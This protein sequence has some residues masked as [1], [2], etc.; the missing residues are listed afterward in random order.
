MKTA[1]CLAVLMTVSAPAFPQGAAP[2]PAPA[3][4]TPSVQE[5]VYEGEL[6]T[7]IATG[8]ESTGWRLRRRTPEGRREYIEVLLTADV[9]QG[10]RAN[11]R[12]QVR[13]TMKT[14][15]YLERGDVEVL[16]AKSVVEVARTR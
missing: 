9:A 10:V 5:L 3:A 6:E 2:T 14:R 15:H 1:V 7:H 13:G 16:V 4:K 12:V 11:T 8:G